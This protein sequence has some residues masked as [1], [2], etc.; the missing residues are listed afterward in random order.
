[1]NILNLSNKQ[2][3]T[4]EQETLSFFNVM[5]L[6]PAAY[7]THNALSDNEWH[8]WRQIKCSLHKRLHTTFLTYAVE[9][10]KTCKHT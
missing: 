2:I 6:V 10:P 8:Y 1:M 5:H 9:L 7:I 4:A 3:H